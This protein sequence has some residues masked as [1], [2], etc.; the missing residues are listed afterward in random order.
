L[1][2]Q[3][4]HIQEEYMSKGHSNRLP[5]GRRSI[6][7]QAYLI[8]IITHRRQSRFDQLYPAREVIKSLY[9]TQRQDQ[10]ETLAYVLMPDHLHWLLILRSGELGD[11]VRR[12]K[13][14]TAR[15]VNR[16]QDTDGPL[17]QLG[18]HDHA[19]RMDE[20]FRR[21]AR[22]IV[23]N[24]LRKGIVDSVGDYPHWDALWLESGLND[25]G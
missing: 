14:Y 11:I 6:L 25:L 8:T 1:I 2:I 10:L 18:F 17:W 21:V 24:P 9:A 20:E 22:Y 13:S 3:G 5:I 15:M 16:H 12:F 23:A 7:N 19:L 4:N